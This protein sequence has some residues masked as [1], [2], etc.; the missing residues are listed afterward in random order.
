MKKI[1]ILIYLL[2]TALSFAKDVEINFHFDIDSGF[3]YY[4]NAGIDSIGNLTTIEFDKKDVKINLKDGVYIFGFYDNKDRY[5]FRKLYI[6]NNRDFN[7]FFVPRK[8]IAVTGTVFEKNHPLKNVKFTFTDS[9]GR[10]YP[11]MSDNEGKYSLMLPP[12]KY[13]VMSSQFGYE[14]KNNENYF[15]FSQPDTS[16]I[17]PVDF[18]KSVGKIKGKVLSDKNTPVQ[19][20]KIFISNNKK[21]K[22]IY[23]DIHGNFSTSLDE[24]ITSMKI[25][26]EGFSPTAFIDKFTRSD[27]TK[28]HKFILRKKT[29]FISGAVINDV[30]PIKNHEIYLFL[31]NGALLDKT[32]TNENGNFKFLNIDKERVYIYIPE[33]ENYKEYKSELITLEE[34]KTNN[35]ITLE[36]K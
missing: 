21:E 25:S 26:K 18:V 1:I 10:E 7:I 31:I 2:I 33:T 13:T 12:E 4:S 6:T 34:S 3:I 30:L 27:T 23:T 8:S 19:K 28:L 20:A 9:V 35:V 32:T 24:G 15:D 22:I 29:Y 17:I 14:V 11:I 36:K 5:L 16:Y